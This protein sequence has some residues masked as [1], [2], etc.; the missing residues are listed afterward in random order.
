MAERVAPA[1][2]LLDDLLARCTFPPAGTDAACAFSGGADSTALIVL[3]G[4]ARLGVTAI[5]VDHGLRP[6]SASEAVQAQRIAEQV[7]VAFERRTVRVEPGPNLEARA[8]QARLAA[9]P[10]GVLTGHTIDDQAET[11]LINLLR[12]AGAG[13]LSAMEPGFT[14]PLLAL[15]R[16]ETR[17]LCSVL[18]ID[19]VADPSNTDARFLRN[20]VRAELLPLLD[21]LAGRDVAVLLARTADV[22]RDDNRLLDEL[23]AGIDPGDARAVATADPALARRALRTLIGDGYP[24]DLATLNRALDVAR[25][26]NR[27]CELGAGRRLER[28][29]QRL[30][31]VEDHRASRRPDQ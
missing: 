9:L 24:P 31:I 13:G 18:G 29:R 8:R 10:D 2:R 27:A 1:D 25:G 5:H 26:V 22:L 11:V 20:R 23:A 7:G 4:R 14:K 15:R 3:A 30:E 17:E 21:D 6:T 28:H 19:T 16:A 12:G